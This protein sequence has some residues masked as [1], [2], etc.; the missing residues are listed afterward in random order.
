[1]KFL[2]ITLRSIRNFDEKTIHFQ[3]GLNII[4][5]PNESGKSTI[6]DSLLFSLTGN[7]EEIPS[8]KNWDAQCSAIE[9]RFETDT[10]Q[11]YRLSR[12]LY[13]EVKTKLESST[14]IVEDPDTVRTILNEQF[15]TTSKTVLENSIIIKHN[16]MEILRKMDSKEV[17]KNQMRVALAE[18]AGRHTEDVMSILEGSISGMERAVVDLLREI[19][20]RER[21]L[22]FYAGMD[23]KYTKLTEKARV[24]GEDLKEN[25]KMLDACNSHIQY[26]ELTKEIEEEKRKMEEIENFEGYLADIPFDKA[27]EIEELQ[28]KSR[29]AQEKR[30]GLASII[31]RREEELRKERNGLAQKGGIF[32]WVGSLF[33]RSKMKEDRVKR[34]LALE[35]LLKN[36]RE[37]LHEMENKIQ[38][39]TARIREITTQLSSSYR[40]KGT[41][42]LYQMKVK[43]ER[44]IAELL[45]GWTNEDLKK[46]ILQK[47]N[48]ADN[49]RSAIHRTYP[50]LLEEDDLTVQRMREELEQK[51]R[52]LRNQSD[53]SE[54][55][56]Q[57][58]TVR[59]REKDRTQG[60]IDALRDRKKELETKKEIDQITL[61]TIRC[62]YAD[63]RDLFIPQLEE[64]AG[65]ILKRITQGK[66]TK[67]SIRREDMETFVELRDRTISVNSLSQ[68]TK[69]QVYLAL[70]IALSELLSGGR[71]LPLLFDESFYTSDEKRLRET[72]AVLKELA[73]D[74]QIILFTHNEE[75]LQYGNPIILGSDSER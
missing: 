20:E 57:D 52:M 69:D 45:Q 66:Y 64:N 23:E 2:T 47:Q 38:D 22:S 49:L 19:E 58:V 43:Y 61:N 65:R 12:T 30:E 29:E 11:E 54:K 36:D 33:G 34:I 13:P 15:G 32:G 46:R 67:I 7:R 62:V 55:E 73:L 6:L 59:K 18:P 71:N 37:N 53:N 14:T 21:E 26:G 31:K 63:L 9:A 35:E 16:E 50:H 51:G 5:G 8:L 10:Q 17:I 68:G 74:N 60:E 48:D 1:M 3:D 42:Y 41:E 56:L 24:H 40:D 72:F 4:C 70:R 28:N 39:T 44:K 75:F 25:E 27:E